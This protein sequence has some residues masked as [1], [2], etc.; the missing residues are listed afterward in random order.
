MRVCSLFTLRVRKGKARSVNNKLL[1]PRFIVF[2]GVVEVPW[3]GEP[4]NYASA[5]ISFRS[6]FVR[7]F[8]AS[9][10]SQMRIT[11]QP[12]AFSRR[13]TRLSRA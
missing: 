7:A 3:F 8:T 12:F 6:S 13:V 5:C 2:R 4:R 10:C 1:A 9:S 11:F